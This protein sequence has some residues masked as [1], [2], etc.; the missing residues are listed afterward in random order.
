MA[1]GLKF[2]R[3]VQKGKLLNYVVVLKE[4]MVWAFII[5]YL[6]KKC[7]YFILKKQLVHKQL[8]HIAFFY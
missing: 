8:V 6:Y 5:Y 3:H 2:K 4:L 1:I 7:Y